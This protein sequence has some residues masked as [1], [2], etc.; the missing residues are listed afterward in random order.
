M[1]GTCLTRARPRPLRPEALLQRE[2]ALSRYRH[3][4]LWVLKNEPFRIGRESR[5][6]RTG[7][8]LQVAYKRYP[9]AFFR[10]DGSVIRTCGKQGWYGKGWRPWSTPD[11]SILK[12]KEGAGTRPGGYVSAPGPRSTPLPGV[13]P[14]AHRRAFFSAL[15]GDTPPWRRVSGGPPCPWQGRRWPRRQE[16][17]LSESVS[18]FLSASST[19]Q[20]EWGS[21]FKASRSFS[22]V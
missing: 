14:G 12:Q 17:P 6:C 4:I 5:I 15:R 9:R 2:Q 20:Q 16:E 3:I 18:F 8:V 10:G 7:E 22:S 13:R 19:L 1:R 11:A 21:T